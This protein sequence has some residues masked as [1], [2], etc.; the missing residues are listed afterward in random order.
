V[1]EGLWE[2]FQGLLGLGAEV[3][4]VS[5]VQMALRTIVIYAF[6]PLL[7]RLGSKRFLSEASAFDV[8][9]SIMLG[10]IM[11]RA[12]N[13]SAPLIPTLASGAILLGLHWLF[14]L[15]A[16]RMHWFGSLVKGNAVLLIKDGAIQEEGMRRASIT[17]SDLAQALRLQTNQSDPAKVERAYL[18]RNGKISIIPY[19]REAQ[20]VNVSVEDGVQTVR[21]ELAKSG[22]ETSSSNNRS[23]LNHE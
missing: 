3:S 5:V 2:Q 16:V 11:S 7:V 15:L 6:T 18:E 1:L 21:V 22:R 17:S 8:I 20:I 19:A 10:S 9:V 14:A 12:I 4:D 13:G 23:G